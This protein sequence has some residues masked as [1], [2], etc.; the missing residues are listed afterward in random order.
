MVRNYGNSKR[1]VTK[2]KR[3]KREVDIR[4]EVG[5]ALFLRQQSYP[6]LVKQSF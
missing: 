5:E 6:T 3:E 1:V 4:Q 2:T